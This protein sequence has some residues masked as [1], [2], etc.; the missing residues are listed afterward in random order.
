MVDMKADINSSGNC[1]EK[2]AYMETV[3]YK[4]GFWGHCQAE[5]LN[6]CMKLDN[7]DKSGLNCTA[8]DYKRQK[9]LYGGKPSEQC[10]ASLPYCDGTC[11][12]YNPKF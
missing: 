11:L 5:I 4:C 3:C 12:H 10:R 2:Q 7:E 9:C 8:S 1:L 6:D